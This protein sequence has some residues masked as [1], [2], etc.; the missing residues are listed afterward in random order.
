MSL[1]THGVCVAPGSI[2]SRA[3]IGLGAQHHDDLLRVR[4]DIGWQRNTAA[5]DGNVAAEDPVLISS[6]RV[7]ELD[8]QDARAR[9]A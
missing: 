5:T 7:R 8:V 9:S 6:L 3:G 4:P 2:P 1:P